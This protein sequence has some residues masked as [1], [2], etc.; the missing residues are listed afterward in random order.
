MKTKSEKY[1]EYLT[2]RAEFAKLRKPPAPP[3][4]EEHARLRKRCA[5]QRQELRR[6]NAKICAV[7][8]SARAREFSRVSVAEL[9]HEVRKL[10]SRAARAEAR[11]ME[12]ESAS[13]KADGDT[14]E[15]AQ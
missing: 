4:A 11:V 2:R 1:Q 13:T 14:T 5:D 8:D 6:L 12:L 7:V 3:T 9:R 15:A 10:A